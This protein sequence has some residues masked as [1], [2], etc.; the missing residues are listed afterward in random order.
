MQTIHQADN[1]EEGMEEGQEREGGGPL[2][3]SSP[4]GLSYLFLQLEKDQL[5]IRRTCVQ[6]EMLE[7]TKGSA[8]VGV[9]FVVPLE[10][11]L[12]VFTGVLDLSP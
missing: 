9:H 12:S 2:S 3:V 6:L 5:C 10:S 1:R 4:L 7:V 11:N 8:S